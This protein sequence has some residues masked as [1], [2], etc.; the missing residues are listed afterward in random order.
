MDVVGLWAGA[1]SW[2][3]EA[4]GRGEQSGSMWRAGQGSDFLQMGWDVPCSCLQA[5]V[6]EKIVKK[7]LIKSSLLW[8]ACH[9]F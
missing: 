4:K 8:L 7:S 9:F 5:A 1:C 3:R 2:L 6:R